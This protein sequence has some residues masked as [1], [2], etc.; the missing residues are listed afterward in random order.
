MNGVMA[1]RT[2]AVKERRFITSYPRATLR[3]AVPCRKEAWNVIE[4]A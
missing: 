1:R 4:N 3:A 2:T